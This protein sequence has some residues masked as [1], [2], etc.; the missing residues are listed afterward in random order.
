MEASVGT[1]IKPKGRINVRNSQ[2]MKK[3]AF[4]AVILI[5]GLVSILLGINQ[6]SAAEITV[7]YA[8]SQ[9]GLSQQNAVML[10][11]SLDIL[12]KTLDL[13]SEQIAVTTAPIKNASV[14]NSD[15]TELKVSL[16]KI[17][18]TL[19]AIEGSPSN[20]ASDANQQ[21]L[22]SA[23]NITSE[24]VAN[25]QLAQVESTFDLKSLTWP[26]T[27]VLAVIVV[28]MVTIVLRRKIVKAKIINVKKNIQ[29]LKENNQTTSQTKT[30]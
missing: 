4:G 19:T 27:A 12:K 24:Q 15:L 10:K 22:A 8:P 13:L 7:N 30:V 26:A 29:E 5:V 20:V 1:L 23:G 17:D 3:F 2:K 11:Q 9:A 6:A 14:I 21:N 28:A 16:H 18:A 25:T